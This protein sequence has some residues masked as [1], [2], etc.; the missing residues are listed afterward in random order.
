MA[1]VTA[2]G[3]TVPMDEAFV[4]DGASM[5]YTGDPNGGARNVINCRCVTL[6]IE[7]EWLMLQ[8]MEQ[9]FLWMKLL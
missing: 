5:Q 9:L 2:N 3:T 7:E 6:Y 1:H 4:V 8:P